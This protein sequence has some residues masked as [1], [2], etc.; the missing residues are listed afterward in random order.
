MWACHIVSQ[1]TRVGVESLNNFL[2]A[3]NISL[4]IANARTT[5]VFMCFL[6]KPFIYILMLADSVK[7]GFPFIL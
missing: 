6:F 2:I 4:D 7:L 1:S 3:A 5:G